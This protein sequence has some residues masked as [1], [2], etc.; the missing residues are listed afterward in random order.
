M[1]NKR[2]GFNDLESTIERVDPVKYFP[3][4]ILNIIFKNYLVLNSL[5]ELLTISRVPRG[6]NSESHHLWEFLSSPSDR[7]RYLLW[8]ATV[9]ERK[10]ELIQYA[11]I[12]KDSSSLKNLIKNGSGYKYIFEY[13]RITNKIMQEFKEA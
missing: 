12:R 9:I 3:T 5:S 1:S 10:K 4:E 13:D 6:W 7:K 8:L 11:P 2:E